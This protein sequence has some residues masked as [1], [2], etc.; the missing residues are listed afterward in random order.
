MAD[1]KNGVDLSGGK[2][3]AGWERVRCCWPRSRPLWRSSAQGP[4]FETREER[5]RVDVRLDVLQ[6]ATVLT[7]AKSRQ[8][9]NLNCLY[10]YFFFFLLNCAKSAL[11]AF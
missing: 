9:W 11:L 3:A 10:L 1:R 7:V 2:M 6:L 8:E 4:L 5:G